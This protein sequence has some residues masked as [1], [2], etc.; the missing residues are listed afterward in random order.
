MEL[1]TVSDLR[2]DFATPFRTITAVDGV[3]FSLSS[4]SVLALV[5]ESGCGKSVTALALARLLSPAAQIRRGDI[6]FNGESVLQMDGKRLRRLRGR[7]LAYVFQDP[8]SA[9]NPVFPVGW[10]V[11]EVLRLHDPVRAS[12][13]EVLD[14]FRRVDLPER[15]FACYPNDLSGG[16]RQ[17][18]VIAM[19]LACRPRLLI[20]DEPT[21]ALDVTLQAQIMDLIL[22]A[23]QDLGMGVLFITHNLGLVAEIADEVHVMYAGHVMES[24]PVER[25]L[26]APRHP[27]TRGLLE[28]VPS[29]TD[30][31]WTRE[32]CLAGIRGAVGQADIAA[33][34]C[35]FCS[36]CDEA[37]PGCHKTSPPLFSAGDPR[38]KVRCHQKRSTSQ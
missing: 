12:R 2:I 4:G 34:G 30:A 6:V 33:A 22:A 37:L 21:T 23:K 10:Q 24:G 36:R 19:A 27:Y 31:A 1:L 13:A 28:A 16:M 20:A 7:D 14:V 29:L 3:S 15:V 5:G 9:L 26:S 32:G 35:R 11:Q 17:R 38:H 8:A 25:V 18:V